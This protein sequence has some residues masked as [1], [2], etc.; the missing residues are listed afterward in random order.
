LPYLEKD[1]LDAD[2]SPR[3]YY[4]LIDG[5]TALPHLVF[6]HEGLGCIAMWGDF[7]AKLC[8]ATGCP[9]M[10]YDRLGYGKSSALKHAR[11]IHY[12]H[13]YALYELPELLEK[14]LPDTPYILIGHSDGGSIG[15]IFS[16]ERPLLLHG[17]VTEAAHV[18]VE[19]ETIAGIKVANDAWAKGKLRGLSKYHGDKTATLYQAWSQTWLSKW[20]TSWNIEYLLPSIEV[21]LLII[22]GSDD[23]YASP[24]HAACIAS[25]TS[26]HTQVEIVD[27]CAHVPHI[28]AQAAVLQLMADF[29]ARVNQ[30]L[31]PR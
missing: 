29:I 15:L 10:V 17:I 18:F 16:A 9:G 2:T 31:L 24:N 13:D 25:K 21:P 3:L 7:P 11:T 1:T 22:Q 4:Q 5:N 12:L 27:N 19:A 20:F 30:G 28:E 8:T 23:Q 26:G 14:V 6:L